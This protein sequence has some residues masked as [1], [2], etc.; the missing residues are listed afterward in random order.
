M[1]TARMI[2]LTLVS[3]SPLWLDPDACAFV[4]MVGTDT[5]VGV[6]G[7]MYYVTDTAESVVAQVEEALK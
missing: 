5:A 7:R 4:T 6:E 2:K 1:G 3:G